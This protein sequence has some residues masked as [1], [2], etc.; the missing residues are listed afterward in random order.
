MKNRIISIVLGSIFIVLGFTLISLGAGAVYEQPI[1]AQA[2][3]GCVNVSSTTWTA[4]PTT[5]D[6]SR[7]GLYATVVSTAA[8][9]MAGHIGT[10]TAP[11]LGTTVHPIIFKPGVTQY[12]GLSSASILYMLSIQTAAA[13][14]TV[15]FQEIRQ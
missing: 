9:N 6:T 2:T 7:F 11:T 13:T 5:A 1:N 14:E 8:A 4:V 15:C 12:H 10:T 3:A